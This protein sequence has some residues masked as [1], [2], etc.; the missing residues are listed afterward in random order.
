MKTSTSVWHRPS[1]TNGLLLFGVICAT[2]SCDSGPVDPTTYVGGA[3][4]REE[5]PVSFVRGAVPAYVGEEYADVQTA[6]QDKPDEPVAPT[7]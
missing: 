7:F 6:L 5:Q 3:G 4:F 2:A 1:V